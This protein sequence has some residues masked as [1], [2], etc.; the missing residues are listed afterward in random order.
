MIRPKR[1]MGLLGATVLLSGCGAS[2]AKAGPS[3]SGS[4]KV[5]IAQ[6]FQSLLYLPL[7]VAMD[8]GYFAS[9]GLQVTKVTSNSG[10]NA[11]A[12]VISGS[13]QFSLQ[14]PM[15]ATLSD[16]KGAS[17][18]PV[19]AVVNGVPVWIVG[20]QRG[21][22]SNLAGQNIATAIPPSTSTYLLQRAL[23]QKHMK[24]NL[25]FVELGTEA[26]PV[27]AGKAQYGVVYEPT[28]EEAVAQGLKVV[29]SF[30]HQ[31]QSDYAF[32][33]IDTSRAFIAKHPRVVQEFVDGI[34][35]SLQ[36]I[37]QHP[38]GTIQIAIKEFPTLPP[39]VVKAGVLRMIRDKVY[40]TSPVITP[41]EF[42]NA[43]ELQEFLGN[44]HPGQVS[45]ADI[46]NTKFARNAK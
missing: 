16:I 38:Q 11:V 7:Y 9:E 24:A 41:S 5:V 2:S 25:E 17:V 26:A 43:L 14:D 45:Y 35:K 34:D 21:S 44:I 46:V 12:S 1:L 40:A 33:S 22:F 39:S 4:T 10:A 15:I 37:A 32:S 42:H 13:A 29:Y 36:Y 30:A 18:V 8:K 23:K 6:A 19:A 28:V 20:R 27:L 3:A 31:Y